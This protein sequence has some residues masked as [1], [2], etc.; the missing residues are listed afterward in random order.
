MPVPHRLVPMK[1][2]M[3]LRDRP[4]VLML[5]VL[6]VAVGMVMFERFVIVLVLVAFR[7]VQPQADSHQ[8]PGDQQPRGYAL[9]QHKDSKHRT[10]KGRQRVIGSG[11]RRAEVAQ[12]EDEHHKADANAE[13]TDRA[14]RTEDGNGRQRGY[15]QQGQ[16]E[17]DHSRHQ[18]LEHG[19]DHGIGR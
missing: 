9:I 19:D 17:I 4:V 3:G 15:T 1:M 8:R 12:P 16:A 14:G 7:Q 5:M 6:V 11:P 18:T 13:E 2:R 10:N